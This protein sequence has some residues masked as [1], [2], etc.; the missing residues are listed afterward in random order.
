[1]AIT[2]YPTSGPTKSY[3]P[4][5]AVQQGCAVVSSTSTAGH[6]LPA[7]APNSQAIGIA[8]TPGIVGAAMRVTRIGDA[9]AV[10]GAAITPGQYCKTNASGQLI[11]VTGAPGG[12]EN[13]EGRAESAAVN[14]NDLFILFVLPSVL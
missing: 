3:Q 9:Q 6:V 13:I 4:D 7:S 5:S 11:P 8:D 10:A 1:M 14:P 12:G 2:G